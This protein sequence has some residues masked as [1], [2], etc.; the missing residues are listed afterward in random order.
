MLKFIKDTVRRILPRPLFDWLMKKRFACQQKEKD[1]NHHNALLKLRNK[2]KIKLAFF[3]INVDSWK[4]DTLYWLFDNDVN[5]EPIVVI[6]PF[7]SK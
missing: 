3:L 7:V 6:C 2:N 1:K 5:F 4:L